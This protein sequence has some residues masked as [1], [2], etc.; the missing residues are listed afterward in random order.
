MA[1]TDVETL[2]SLAVLGNSIDRSL[3]NLA[4]VGNIKCQQVII[5]S[6]QWDEASVGNLAAV[7]EGEA[8]DTSARGKRNNTAITDGVVQTR[9]VKALDEL[10]VGKGR[11]L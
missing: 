5:V 4:V 3:R 2:E 11:S 9:K 1:S 8:F 7:C 6:D 10:P